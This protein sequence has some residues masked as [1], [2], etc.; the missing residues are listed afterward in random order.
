MKIEISYP[1]KM[2]VLEVLSE[3][4]SANPSIFSVK[5]LSVSPPP[6]L[7]DRAVLSSDEMDIIS[8]GTALRKNSRLPF[9]EAVLLSCFDSPFILDHILEAAMFHNQAV[10]DWQILESARLNVESLRNLVMGVTSGEIITVSSRVCL[11]DG[12]TGH[13]PMLD[14]H[15]P[16]SRE[17]QNLVVSILKHMN[18][19]DGFIL[20][21]DKSY[22]FYGKSLLTDEELVKFLGCSLLWS[23]IVDR[24]WIAHQLIEASCALRIS[25]KSQNTGLPQVV[26]R[27]TQSSLDDKKTD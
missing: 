5:L 16:I 1:Q 26:A 22:H 3:I 8:K 12:G 2:D 4:I 10:E 11:N 19:C 14:F 18:V 20:N 27:V 15:C 17:N 13:I 21:S 9:W 7:Q 6:L 24:A 23:P 25:P